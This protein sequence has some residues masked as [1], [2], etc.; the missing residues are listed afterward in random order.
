MTGLRTKIPT[1]GRTSLVAA[2]ATF[3]VLVAVSAGAAEGVHAE[4]DAVV[5]EMSDYLGGLKA[6]SVDADVDN[7]IVD[8][9]GQKLQLSS[10]ATVLL[11]RPGRMRLTRESGVAKV[12]I[13]YDGKLLT[14]GNKTRNTYAQFE[15]PG[16]IDDALR[17][18]D[19]E[20][21]M[22]VPAGDLFY[23][24][25]YSGLMSGVVSGAYLGW[26]YV[27]GVQCHH[28]SF[29]ADQVDWQ[30]WVRTGDVPLPMKYVITSK[31][32]TGAPQFAVRFGGWNT[33][34]DID[35]DQFEFTPPKGATKLD[36]VPVNE[37]GQLVMEEVQ[38]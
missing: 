22:E 10:S 23:A 8:F 20:I 9:S 6:F 3:L 30:I 7:E 19:T 29:R 5:R 38:Q 11:D 32:V 12:G 27:D 2:A 34:P 33:K 17:T 28:L 24:D 15:R 18:L 14:V 21:G 1:V 36:S 25:S 16:T 13:V 31:W 4:A 35:P 37:A 26:A